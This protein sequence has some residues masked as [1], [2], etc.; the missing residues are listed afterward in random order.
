MLTKGE[1]G[2]HTPVFT[3]YGPLFYFPTTDVTDVATLPKDVRMVMPGDNA[4][5]KVTLIAVDGSLR[6]AI[7]EVFRTVGSGVAASITV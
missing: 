2:R 3:D 6:H 7:C 4:I 1:G 5:M